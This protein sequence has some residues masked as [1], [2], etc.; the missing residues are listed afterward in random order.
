MSSILHHPGRPE[1]DTH[2]MRL[3]VGV[4]AILMPI[5]V[6]VFAQTE[7]ESISAGYCATD[8]A[9]NIFVGCLFAIS[10]FFLSYNGHNRREMC[11]SKVAAIAAASIALFPCEC[12]SE[13]GRFISGVHYVSA[14]VMFLILTYFC[15]AFNRRAK[16]KS[17]AESKRRA[18]I[19]GVCGLVMLL[20]LSAMVYGLTPDGV[21]RFPRIIFVAEQILLYAFGISWLVASQTLP[22]LASRE[23]R[24]RD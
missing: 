1:I 10:A 16:A 5:L 24:R 22:Y 11:L 20:A 15:L 8:N 13:L 7:L 21:T 12:A 2:T 3:I 9:R 6:L 4:I 19:Y 23:E 17:S 14:A 18:W